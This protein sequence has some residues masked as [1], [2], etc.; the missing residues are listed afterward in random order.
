MQAL[1]ARP[2]T[3]GRAGELRRPGLQRV[4]SPRKPHLCCGNRRLA[5]IAL[6]QPQTP[7][8]VKAP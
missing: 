6:A 8:Q 3:L 2:L 7:R 1:E 4:F 5:V